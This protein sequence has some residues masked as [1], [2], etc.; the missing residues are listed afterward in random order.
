MPLQLRE[1]KASR[2][3]H[4]LGS[5]QASSNIPRPPR[6]LRLPL[7]STFSGLGPRAAPQRPQHGENVS[8]LTFGDAAAD[9]NVLGPR[10]HHVGIMCYHV[11]M[12][13]RTQVQLTEEQLE[14]VR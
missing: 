14:A 11:G 9:S 3:V 6:P 7:N 10:K 1:P 13:V 8:Q 4:P 5:Q 12:M 2:S